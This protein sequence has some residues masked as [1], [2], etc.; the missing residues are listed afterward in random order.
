[1]LV[2]LPQITFP[3]SDLLGAL[4]PGGEFRQI[5]G[6]SI[7]LDDIGISVSDLLSLHAAVREQKVGAGIPGYDVA[8]LGE[9]RHP[10]LRIAFIIDE[11]AEQLSVRQSFADVQGQSARRE[12]NKAARLHDPGDEVGANLVDPLSKLA[13]AL[14][15]H[16]R[17]DHDDQQRHQ[18][19]DRQK[20]AEQTPRRHSGGVHDDEFGIGREL[21]RTKAMATMKRSGDDHDKQGYDQ[22][23]QAHEV[24]KALALVGHQVDVAQRLSDPHQHGYADEHHHERTESGAENITPDRPHPPALP[25]C[26]SPTRPHPGPSARGDAVNGDRPRPPGAT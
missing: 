25:Q 15:R 8:L 10:F 18:R 1:L 20:W 13:Q 23:G 24:Q 26:R 14:G 3:R 2:E 16:I 7:E 12:G 22:S 6:V 4:R 19:C 5:E 21:L 9:E 11:N 17:G